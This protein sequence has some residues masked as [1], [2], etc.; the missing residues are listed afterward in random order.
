MHMLPPAGMSLI[1]QP[2]AWKYPK[3]RVS[4]KEL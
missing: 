3:D 2:S 1:V 4:S